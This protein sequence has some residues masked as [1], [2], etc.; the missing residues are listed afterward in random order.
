MSSDD[1]PLFAW[2]A[3]R[4][5][6]SAE[7]AEPA[8]DDFTPAAPVADPLDAFRALAAPAD[9]PILRW[10]DS[11]TVEE[12]AAVR[13]SMGPPQP[14]ELDG[15]AQI[16]RPVEVN[17]HA[18]AWVRRMKRKRAKTGEESAPEEAA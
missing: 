17:P 8:W 10:V 11:M 14:W 9:D 13:E 5:V 12:R 18:E 16:V 6:A 1:L 15:E 4:P 2:A 3:T 7:P